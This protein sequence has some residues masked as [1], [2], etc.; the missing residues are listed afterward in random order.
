MVC[1]IAL[2][3]PEV[4]FGGFDDSPISQGENVAGEV[5]F[6]TDPRWNQHLIILVHAHETL[7]KWPVTKAAKSQTIGGVVIEA[8]FPWNDVGSLRNREGRAI[9]KNPCDLLI[10]RLSQLLMSLI[11]LPLHSRGVF[12]NLWP[13]WGVLQWPDLI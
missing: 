3:R 4:F 1:E 8:L 13:S 9:G 10:C 7:V 6:Q 5:L 11:P 12:R 2:A